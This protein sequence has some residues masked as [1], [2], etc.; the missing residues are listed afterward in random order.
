MLLRLR[1]RLRADSVL[2]T[3]IYY[4]V[5]RPSRGKCSI[6]RGFHK[7]YGF[8]LALLRVFELALLMWN[9]SQVFR[10]P[11]TGGSFLLFLWKMG[12]VKGCQKGRCECVS[13]VFPGRKGNC[14]NISRVRLKVARLDAVFRSYEEAPTRG[15]VGALLG[16]RV[17]VLV[18]SLK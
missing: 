15:F 3:H 16:E 8:I 12:G 6:F 10:R 4:R 18:L 7:I 14:G 17:W 1:Q 2:A 9:N 5:S 11:R 13:I